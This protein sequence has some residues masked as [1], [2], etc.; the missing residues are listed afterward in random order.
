MLLLIICC[1]VSCFSLA[2]YALGSM[3]EEKYCECEESD[4]DW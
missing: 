2:L 3:N 4:T 1:Y